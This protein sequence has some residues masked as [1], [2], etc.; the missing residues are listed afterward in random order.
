[1]FRDENDGRWI[2]WVL[3]EVDVRKS[4]LKRQRLRDLLFRREV[5]AHEDDAKALA[6]TLVLDQRVPEIVLGDQTG[7][8]QA[9][10]YLLAHRKPSGL[11]ARLN[12]NHDCTNAIEADQIN[13]PAISN[14]SNCYAPLSP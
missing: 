3:G 5:H 2:G 1:L 12:R 8:D 7:L 14:L 6:G 13:D 9:L 11:N 4:E 10:A